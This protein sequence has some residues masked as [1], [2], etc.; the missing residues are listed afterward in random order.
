M[1]FF[2]VILKLN[3]NFG[4]MF[5]KKNLLAIVISSLV[6]VTANAEVTVYGR[7]DVSL[8]HADETD[9]T[10]VELVSNASRIGL[11]GSEEINSG[12]K[13][14]YQFEYQ[15]EVDDGATSANQTFSQRNIYIGLQGA[16]GTVTAGHFDT[17]TKIAQ[18]KIDLFND[19]EGDI[20]KFLQ[21]ENRVK[22]IVQYTTPSFGG[23]FSSSV[24]YITKEVED[25]DPGVSASF[26][27]TSNVFYVAVAYDK[28]LLVEGTDLARLVG[29]Y[30]IGPVQLGALIEAYDNGVDDETGGV[31][32]ALWSLTD[33][34][35]LK[36][37]YGDSE[38]KVVDG[39]EYSLG[40]DYKLS[41]N[42]TVYGY[43]TNLEG[44]SGLDS[45]D[46]YLGVGMELKF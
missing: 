16:M 32:S 2:E 30:N 12:L 19:R 36:A 38:T 37:Q 22:N 29:R 21:G 46:K 10:K 6:A 40:A 27:Y 4:G 34:W 7:G 45:D 26:S 15:T 24:A 14:I 35:A 13:A 8:Q 20:T 1:S 11:K 25:Q 42:T 44:A 33:E 28:D 5:M 41:K 39:K 18:E 31:V 23:G 43:Y 9:D 3:P 17:P